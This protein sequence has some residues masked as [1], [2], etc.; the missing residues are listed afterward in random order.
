MAPE[1]S[2]VMYRM[3]ATMTGLH[4][5]GVPL[6]ADFELDLP[7]FLTALDQHDPALIFL[8]LPNNPTGNVFAK[9]DVERIVERANGLVVI[10]EA[11][12]AFTDTDHLDMLA[13]Y[14]NVVVMRT[15]SK[16]GLAGLRLGYLVGQPAWIEQF[17]KVRLPYNINILTQLTATFAL[18]HYATLQQQTQAIRAA[19]ADLTQQLQQ[20]PFAK[21]WPSEANFILA[22]TAP[23]HAPRLH[24]HLLDQN[25]L[26]K[27]LDGSHPALADCLRFTVGTEY[28]NE[29]LLAALKGYF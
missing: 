10:D 12:T 24:Q 11:Y 8:A 2:F 28:E 18:Q 3:I 9:A 29:M 20:L 14:P 17:N 4:Y 5:V 1:P 16:I 22:R 23:G 25:V 13:R 27:K 15:V 7:R 19:R 21:V 26:I 6:T